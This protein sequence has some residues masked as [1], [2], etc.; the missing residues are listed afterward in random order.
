MNIVYV[1]L[2]ILLALWIVGNLHRRARGKDR[3]IRVVEERCSGCGRCVKRCS[4]GVLGMV[5]G[6]GGRM[7][8]AVK[9]PER[10]TACG[11]CRGK[12]RF[13]ALEWVQRSGEMAKQK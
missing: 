10:C 5:E 6:E 4:K 1:C 13:E 2:G 7:C 9:R 3:L 12:C 11:D 8:A